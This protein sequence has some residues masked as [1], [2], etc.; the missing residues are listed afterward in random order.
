MRFRPTE[1]D[2]AFVVEFDVHTDERGHFARTFDAREFAEHGL[3]TELA[4]ASTSFTHRRGAVRGMHWQAAPATE[5]KLVR[6]VRG[7][8]WDVLADLRPGSPSFGR[9]TAVRLAADAP[10]ALYVPE[11][12][13]HGFQTLEDDTEVTYAISAEHS[14]AHATGFRHDDP[15]LSIDWP[16]PVT[17]I[18]ERDRA[19]PDLSLETL[20]EEAAAPARF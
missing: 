20:A 19:W 15:A 1:L 5:T 9:T 17:V 16:L 7:A 4:Q 3:S 14:P 13:A 12:C 10:L 18:S 8:I 6:C 11:L 2:G